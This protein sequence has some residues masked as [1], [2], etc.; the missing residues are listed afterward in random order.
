M[1]NKIFI[2]IASYRDPALLTTIN[3]AIDNSYDPE[4]LFFG[5]VIQDFDRNIPDLKKY[6]NISMIT[7]H[8]KYAMGAGF[9][10]HKALSLYNNEKYFLQIDSHTVFEKGWD[11]LAIKELKKAQEISN[12]NK[13][14]LSYFPPPFYLESNKK[15]SIIKNNKDRPPYPTKQKP[16][17]NKKGEWTAERIEFEDKQRKLPEMSKTVLGGFIFSESDLIEEVPYDPDISFFGEELCFA[18]RLW[19]RG[20]DIYSPSNNIV[21]HFYTRSEYSKIWKDKNIRKISWKEVEN[22]SKEKQ[23]RVLC[24]IEKGIYGAGKIRSLKKFEGF[25][26]INFKDHYGL[27][28]EK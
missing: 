3:S 14:V 28:K 27:T 26:D 5:L 22:K 25:V 4:R 16:K 19:T 20:W 12:N 7:M 8:P 17:L 6:K 1:S 15:I 21:H 18:M 13:I 23:K 24:G 11:E 9:A 10:R 2:S